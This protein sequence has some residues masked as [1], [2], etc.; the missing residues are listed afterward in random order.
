MDRYKIMIVDDEDE[1]RQG[2]MDL[3]PWSSLGYEFTGAASNGQEALDLCQQCRPDVIICD[4]NMPIMDGLEFAEI[5][6]KQMPQVKL[7]FLT[8]YDEFDYAQQAVKLN[9]DD[10]LLKPLTPD[11]MT[12]LLLRVKE[13]L[14]RE[15]REKQDLQ[16]IKLKLKESLPLLRERYLI[17]WVTGRV[18]YK[19]V[20]KSLESVGVTIEQQYWTVFVLHIEPLPTQSFRIDEELLTFAITNI[21]E[22]WIK[23]SF[24]AGYV[25]VNAMDQ[26][27]FVISSRFTNVQESEVRFMNSADQIRK[28][29]EKYLKVTVTVGAGRSTRPENLPVCY[30]EALRALEYRFLLEESQV[31]FIKDLEQRK[32][33]QQSSEQISFLIDR[34]V[35]RIKVASEVELTQWIEE[36]F[37]E[38][39]SS[40]LS[41]ELYKVHL[42]ELVI[43]LSKSFYEHIGSMSKTEDG[44]L[45]P[46]LHL[47]QYSTLTQMKQYIEEVCLSIVR[48][49]A[50]QREHFYEDVVE[51][52]ILF[53]NENYEDPH[54]SIQV[55]C[56]H[57]HLSSSYFSLIFKK[58][59]GETF[60]EY[61]TGIRLEKARE[62]L[63]TTTLKAYEIAERVGFNNIHYFSM[64]F[65]KVVGVAPSEYRKQ[66]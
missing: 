3:I 41:V 27:V 26:P 5:V 52:A 24:D 35:N 62:L 11:E 45:H 32:S 31:L 64:V 65:K 60:V 40:P 14:D 28:T 34:I 19:K 7:I 29:L 9:V 43:L 38:F 4:I 22:E 36:L 56:D 21:G 58:E 10:F 2:M 50:G 23:D 39:R 48:G 47:L 44:L 46:I 57:L 51:K 17:Q 30:K 20:L 59:T 16:Q 37:V 53:L 33:E 12:Q 1:V 63:R 55:I 13:D 66:F 61:V 8:G 25:W 15:I 54:L 49:V 42:I 18:P 6:M